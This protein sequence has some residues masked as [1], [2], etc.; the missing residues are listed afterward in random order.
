MTN[1]YFVP[2]YLLLSAVV[3]AAFFATKIFRTG[4][5][6]GTELLCLT[7]PLARWQVIFAKYFLLFTTILIN[8]LG[9]G[10][11][12]LCNFA[13]QSSSAHANFLVFGGTIVL[14]FFIELLFSAV[15]IIICIYKRKLFTV[16]T[17]WLVIFGFIVYSNVLTF[18]LKPA[19]NVLNHTDYNL[20]SDNFVQKNT[21]QS[22]QVN[23]MDSLPFTSGL[24]VTQK[25]TAD[26]DFFQDFSEA[27]NVDPKKFYDEWNLHNRNQL[28]TG[29]KAI[30]LAGQFIKILNFNTMPSPISTWF[31][32]SSHNIYFPY[33]LHFVSDQ[34]KISKIQSNIV[35]LQ[36]PYFL[37]ND[38]GLH[39]KLP[40]NLINQTIDIKNGLIAYNNPEYYQTNFLIFNKPI[41]QTGLYLGRN[42]VLNFVDQSRFIGQLNNYGE[43]DEQKFFAILHNY[44]PHKTYYFVTNNSV[45]D[46]QSAPTDEFLANWLEDYD[47]HNKLSSWIGD[48]NQFILYFVNNYQDLVKY[49][50]NQHKDGQENYYQFVRCYD[51]K[52]GQVPF[53]E[54]VIQTSILPILLQTLTCNDFLRHKTGIMFQAKLR[55]GSNAPAYYYFYPFIKLVPVNFPF[56]N[57]KSFFPSLPLPSLQTNEFIAYYWLEPVIR[58]RYSVIALLLFVIGLLSVSVYLYRHRDFA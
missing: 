16:V 22:S 8:A 5:D 38:G 11:I 57:L 40:F 42:N 44:F 50:D 46:Y 30:D 28:F 12:T 7:K 26:D 49:D 3:S 25:T 10:I 13:N 51:L 48:V 4:F 27:M 24:S 45:Y 20:E 18:A 34:Q 33:K 54:K 35:K 52:V 19:Q 15:A 37:S 41:I 55:I 58:V 6:D 14:T 32:Y 2:V 36:L 47:Q 43:L 31:N 39:F 17:C 1:Y 9:A 53:S 29:L 23:Q 21:F 56:L